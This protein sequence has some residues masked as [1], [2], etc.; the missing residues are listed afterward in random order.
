MGVHT[1]ME[2]DG[3]AGISSMLKN[4]TIYSLF[5]EGQN[6]KTIFVLANKTHTFTYEAFL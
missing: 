5:S 1:L 2:I 6:E 4:I 3:K